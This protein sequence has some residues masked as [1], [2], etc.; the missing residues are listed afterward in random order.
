MVKVKVRNIKNKEVS[1]M[2]LPEAIFDYPLKE[3][4][5]YE[6]VKNYNANQRQGTACTKTRSEVAGSGKKLWKQKG[7]GRARMGALRSPLWRKGGTAFGP[8]PRDYSYEMPK[9]ARRN[10]IKSV[11]SDKV[12][13][14]RLLILDELKLSSGKTRDTLKALRHFD[15][16]KLLI[17]DQRGNS[18]LMLSTRNLPHVKAID[19]G[20]MNIYDS[21]KYN[22]I[23][24]SVDAVKRLMEVLK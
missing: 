4:L 2:E 16:D 15:F 14:D 24:L 17:I 19:V 3:H 13:N 5:I 23:M 10:A 9:K 22:Y 11:L 18:D 20:E 7:T 21:L 1:E 6:A 8:K 12:R